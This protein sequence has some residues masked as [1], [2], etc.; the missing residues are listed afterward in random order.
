MTK[1][2]VVQSQQRWEYQC[3]SRRTEV[4]LEKDL[5]EL[6]QSGWELVSVDH[7]K[8]MKGNVCWTAFVKRPATQQ[9]V[10]SSGEE[11][12]REAAAQP[13]EEPEKAETSAAEEGFDLS[14]DEFAIKEE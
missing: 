11:Q 9:A 7:G 13:S 3:V 2:A 10:P 12:A 4:T 14:G 6:G 5:N 1:T 8:D